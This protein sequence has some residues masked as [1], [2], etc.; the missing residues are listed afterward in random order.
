MIPN[1]AEFRTHLTLAQISENISQSSCQGQ[2]ALGSGRRH[3][4]CYIY[5]LYPDL[6]DIP[7]Q[8][9][10]PGPHG[11]PGHTRDFEVWSGTQI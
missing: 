2:P 8:C 4:V 11:Y 10:V 3:A 1:L 7:N 9:L 6:M 5:A